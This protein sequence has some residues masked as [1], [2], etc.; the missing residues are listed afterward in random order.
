MRVHNYIP[1]LANKELLYCDR[2]YTGDADAD[3]NEKS[4]D[5]TNTA[6]GGG[7][8]FYFREPRIVWNLD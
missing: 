8:L 3:S 5:L 2:R 4:I 7:E 1:Q 6:L